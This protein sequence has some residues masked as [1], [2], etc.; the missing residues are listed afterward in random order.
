MQV[1][2]SGVDSLTTTRLPAEEMQRRFHRDGYFHHNATEPWEQDG[3]L[4]ITFNPTIYLSQ[5]LAGDELARVQAH[6]RR[7][8]SDFRRLARQLQATLRRLRNSPNLYWDVR[9]QWFLF[10][11][12]EASAAYHRSVADPMVEICFEPSTPRPGG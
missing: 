3:V 7:H 11:I 5:A 2:I 10:D 8:A 12:C 9:W 1:R 4:T 6:E